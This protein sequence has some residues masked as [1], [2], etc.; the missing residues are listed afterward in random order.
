MTRP[1]QS[2]TTSPV[3]EED[4]GGPPRKPVRERDGEGSSLRGIILR[5]AALMVIDASALAFAYA[6]WANGT[7]VFVAV[8]LAVTVLVNVIFLTGRFMPW[9]WIA[10]G[11]ALM[12]L[13]VIYPIAYTLYVGL[14]NYGD[15]HLFTKGQAVSQ[16][17]SEY[18]VPEGAPSFSWTAYRSDS[19]ELLLYL[20]G[21]QT[22]VATQGDGLVPA[23]ERLGEVPAEPPPEID[24]YGRLSRSEAVGYLPELA[25]LAMPAGAVEGVPGGAVVR[26]LSL[27]VAVPQLPKYDYDALSGELVDNQTGTV[28]Q[29]EDGFF[30]SPEGETISPGFATVVGAANFIRIFSDPDIRGPFL[31]VF[32]WTIVFAALTVVT[33][34]TLGVGLAMLLNDSQLP[35]PGLFRSLMIAPYTIPFFIT[36]L[37][38]VGLLNPVYGPINGVIEFLT[39]LS[40]QWFSDGTLAKVAL[41][42][43]NLWLGFPYMMI[44]CLG[45]LQSIPGDVY[46]AA[47]I[48]GANAW[49]RFRRIT[50][51][52]LLIAVGPLL[53]GCSPSTSTTSP[54]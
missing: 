38:W 25:G 49:N 22:F 47:R 5:L 4:R 50:L 19:G 36:A 34:F 35:L 8:L 10:P 40:P 48:D 9:R 24:G 16:L 37:V 21:D 27:N 13:M 11:L 53:I 7:V 15:G 32:V 54:S 26:V 3:S 33:T 30:T 41:L 23:S 2:G 18:Y 31:G 29:A 6:L 17:E 51:P 43:I 1:P 28:Y 52:L 14:T 12:I 39:G 20:Q 42:G 44:I 45:A 46:E